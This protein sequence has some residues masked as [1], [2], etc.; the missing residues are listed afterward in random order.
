MFVGIRS[1]LRFQ[2]GDEPTTFKSHIQDE[3]YHTHATY[4]VQML[5]N[6]ATL[7]S[8]SRPFFSTGPTETA[9]L[10]P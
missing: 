3:S 2:V 7:T 1:R 5:L 10:M 8:Y 4:I 9:I 6:F